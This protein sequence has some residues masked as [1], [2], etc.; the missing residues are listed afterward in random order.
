M[1][2]RDVSVFLEAEVGDTVATPGCR[3]FAATVVSLAL[4]FDREGLRLTCDSDFRTPSET[5]P[6][7][8]DTGSLSF[9]ILAETA[10]VTVTDL[11]LGN[12][13]DSAVV[14]PS[15]AAS[16]LFD[17][18]IEDT[19]VSDVGLGPEGAVLKVLP[20]LDCE[21]VGFTLAA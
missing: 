8:A 16:T 12:A 20:M 6:W 17:G 5:S 4:A 15:W 11:L 1:L 18:G 7:D 9:G 21:G 14:V 19:I 2:M 13:E 10:P 3:G